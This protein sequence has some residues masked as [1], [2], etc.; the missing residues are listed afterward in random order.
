MALMVSGLDGAAGPLVLLEVSSEITNADL[1]RFS[2]KGPGLR[3]LSTGDGSVTRAAPIPTGAP[4]G[5]DRAEAGRGE[6][7]GRDSGE[8]GAEEGASDTQRAPQRRQAMRVAGQRY[9]SISHQ[10]TQEGLSTVTMRK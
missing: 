6:P 10:A 7:A 9:T 3:G 4:P 2:L 8:G 5:G 1:N